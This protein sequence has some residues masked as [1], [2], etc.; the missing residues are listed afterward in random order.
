MALY[1]IIAR[2][3]SVIKYYLFKFVA[4]GTRLIS[5]DDKNN[6]IV[7]LKMLQISIF[8]FLYFKHTPKKGKSIVKMRIF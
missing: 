4:I 2:F 8:L 6:K 3:Y 5:I 7:F 1:N